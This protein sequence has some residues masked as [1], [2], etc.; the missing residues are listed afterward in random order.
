VKLD[1]LHLN[2]IIHPPVK[3]LTSASNHVLD[4]HNRKTKVERLS[5]SFKGDSLTY[6]SKHKGETGHKFLSLIPTGINPY[7][8]RTETKNGLGKDYYT[9]TLSNIT[10]IVGHFEVETYF[11]SE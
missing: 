11:L 8:L 4:R 7:D 6:F 2:S 3:P 5:V 1:V 9:M 10:H